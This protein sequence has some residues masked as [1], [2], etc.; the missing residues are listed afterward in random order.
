METGGRRRPYWPIT[1]PPD[2]F[3]RVLPPSRAPKGVTKM[4]ARS[5]SPLR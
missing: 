3:E 1:S 4:H 5:Q 2:L